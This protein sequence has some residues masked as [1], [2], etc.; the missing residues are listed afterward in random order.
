MEN[1]RNLKIKTLSN[2]VY[3]ISVDPLIKISDLKEEIFK[4]S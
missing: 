4:I 1:L 2:N 3:N